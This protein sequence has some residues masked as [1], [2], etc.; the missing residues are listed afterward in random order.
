MRFYCLRTFDLD[1][2]VVR[3]LSTIPFTEEDG[4]WHCS[5]YIPKDECCSIRNR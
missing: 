1:A 2:T 5:Y 3:R 4:V